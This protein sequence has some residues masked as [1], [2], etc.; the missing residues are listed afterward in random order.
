MTLKLL[1]QPLQ[2]LHQ[3]L[4][5]HGVWQTTMI[6]TQYR[7]QEAASKLMQQLLKGCR[8]YFNR[9][10]HPKPAPE[11]WLWAWHQRCPLAPDAYVHWRFAELLE[12]LLELKLSE[13]V[14]L[15]HK[16]VAGGLDVAALSP[17][18]PPA[19]THG[20]SPLMSCL[21]PYQSW[22]GD[23]IRPGCTPGALRGTMM[24]PMP[25]EELCSPQG[26][27]I[28]VSRTRRPQSFFWG[29]IELARSPALVTASVIMLEP[30]PSSSS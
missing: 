2:C 12:E 8:R 3:Y 21:A 17:G 10:Q 9:V 27:T 11:E 1:L 29:D 25:G 30:L 26:L 15:S 24:Q 23:T 20:V 28:A 6:V 22:D 13:G 4:S 7:H 16:D 19:A 5:E 14:Q 18:G